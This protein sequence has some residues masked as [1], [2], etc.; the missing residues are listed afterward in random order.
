MSKED[1]I[2]N[3]KKWVALDNQIKQLNT[4]ISKYRNDK[5]ELTSSICEYMDENSLLEKKIEI[6]NGNLKVYEKKEYTP[7]T[8]QYIE[9]CLNDIIKNEN[10]VNMIIQYLKQNR[11][12][13]T[14][15]DIRRNNI[16]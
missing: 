9:Q 7:L 3:I 10:Q 14:S 11:E 6:S 1:F 2:N 15:Y 5:Y 4:G 8:F 12:I 16:K 13:K